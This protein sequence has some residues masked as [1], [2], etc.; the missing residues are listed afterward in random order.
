VVVVWLVG[1]H[2]ISAKS[3]NECE[4]D[5]G[6]DRVGCEHQQRIRD[7]FYLAWRLSG[8]RLMYGGVWFGRN[9]ER[10]TKARAG[11]RDIYKRWWW[12]RLWAI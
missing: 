10:I 3:L 4:E 7:I 8:G 11:L 12:E 9:K 1:Y 2:G 5:G 6:E